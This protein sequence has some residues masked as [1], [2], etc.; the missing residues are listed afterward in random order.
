MA[1]KAL[2]FDVDGTLADTESRGHLPAYNKAFRELG[3]DWRWTRKLYRDL[4]HESGASGRARLRHYLTHYSPPLGKHAR[5]AMDNPE[6]W[7]KSVHSTK[8]RHFGRLLRDGGLPLRTGVARLMREAHAQGLKI[9]LVTNASSASMKAFLAHGL[10]E[11]FRCM[12]DV[13][14]EGAP[15]IAKKPAP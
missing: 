14:V 7:V 5:E 9:A 3:L 8:S 4:L 15:E 13:V 11:E 12:V 2:L 10:G 6:E 1:L